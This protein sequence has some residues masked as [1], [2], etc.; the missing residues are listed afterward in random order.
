MYKELMAYQKAR[1]AMQVFEVSKAFPK[2]ERKLF[3]NRSNKEKF[4]DLFNM[5]RYRK[6]LYEKHF[7]AKIFGVDMENSENHRLARFCSCL[8]T[9]QQNTHQELLAHRRK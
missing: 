8:Q 2:E 4:P 7:I 5:N 9:T 1:S 6:R 3:T